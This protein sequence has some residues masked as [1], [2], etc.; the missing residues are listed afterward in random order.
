MQ[1]DSKATHT[2]L[3]SRSPLGAFLDNEDCKTNGAVSHIEIF[4]PKTCDLMGALFSL[5][6]HEGIPPPFRGYALVRK[7]VNVR[8]L[9]Q[10]LVIN[11]NS[12]VK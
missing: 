12:L 6:C 8:K 3:G 7:I 10:G 2:D 5:L 1:T 11:S 9:N 4:P